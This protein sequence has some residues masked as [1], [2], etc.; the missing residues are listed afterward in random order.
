MNT[1]WGPHRGAVSTVLSGTAGP[2]ANSCLWIF[3][4]K[5]AHLYSG[6]LW[7]F[8]ER[9]GPNVWMVL[10][11]TRLSWELHFPE[12]P[13]LC[14]SW[15]VGQRRNLH[16]MWEAGVKPWPSLSE[17]LL[18]VR[19]SKSPNQRNSICTLARCPGSLFTF[20]LYLLL[21][22]VDFCFQRLTPATLL[23]GPALRLLK[24]VGISGSFMD[25]RA[26]LREWL[27]GAWITKAEAELTPQSSPG[28]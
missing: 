21:A 23:Q 2:S 6:V 5:E 25:P 9:A 12:S 11:S 28:V 19:Y 10:P 16:E 8:I 22:S 15:L 4:Q 24:S 20:S 26:A 13:S 1:S 7:H 14:G 3:W 18:R 17:G 27:M